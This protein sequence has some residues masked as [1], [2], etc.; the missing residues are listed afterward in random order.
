MMHRMD[1]GIAFLKLHNKKPLN[2]RWFNVICNDF[3]LIVT[4]ISIK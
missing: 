1:L 3:Y 4:A 2:M